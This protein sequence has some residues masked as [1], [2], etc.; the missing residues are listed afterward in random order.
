MPPTTASQFEDYYAILG[1]APGATSEE[2]RKAYRKRSLDVHPDRYKG[3]DPDGA[4]AEFLKLTR[5]KEV[6]EDDKARAAFENVIKARAM[7]KEK[8]G[9]Q[10]EARKK[11]R[12]DLEAREEEARKRPRGAAAPPSAESQRQA[13]QQAAA[14][15]EARRELQRELERLRRTGRLDPTGRAPSSA[16]AASSSTTATPP[17]AAKATATLRWAADAP[18][19]EP[20]LRSL[21]SKLLGSAADGMLIALAAGK[22]V[23]ELDVGACQALAAR[24]FEL[25]AHGIRLT[26]QLP[27]GALPP[28][29]AACDGDGVSS[30]ALSGGVGVGV[31]SLPPGWKEQP[32]PDGGQPYYFHVGTRQAQWTRP[33]AEEPLVEGEAPS[34]AA[35]ERHEALTMARLRK[36][37]ERQR[38]RA[39]CTS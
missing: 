21:L 3:E 39:A 33:V 25:A 28:D 11:M 13:Q 9:S 29:A 18:L 22:A 10:D 7:H 15:A 30:R 4:T 23:C 32:A 36:A 6:L 2:V 26:T 24:S 27:P 8:Q 20:A 16:A 38:Q 37:A 1:L 19:S 12:E 35:L 17:L 31:G 5:A 34:V 14:E